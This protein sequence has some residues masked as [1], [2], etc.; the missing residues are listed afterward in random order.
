MKDKRSGHGALLKHRQRRVSHPCAVTCPA[1]ATR[2]AHDGRGYGPVRFHAEEHRQGQ[3]RDDGDAHAD[4]RHQRPAR[5]EADHDDLGPVPAR[6]AVVGT[7]VWKS[8]VDAPP[9][10]AEAASVLSGGWQ[11]RTR[12]KKR[13]EGAETVCAVKVLVR[14]KKGCV[15]QR[16]GW[17]TSRF[18]FLR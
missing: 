11:E 2:T 13:E 12:R 5:E 17:I 3:E 14:E 18:D 9:V 6:P 7:A 16:L 8:V 1:Y 10:K 15:V 4:V